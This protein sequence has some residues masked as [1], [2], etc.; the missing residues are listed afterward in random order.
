MFN[1]A[2]LA[3]EHVTK[4]LEFITNIIAWQFSLGQHSKTPRTPTCRKFALAIA[5]WGSN[6]RDPRGSKY[7]PKVEDLS[8]N[9]LLRFLDIFWVFLIGIQINNRRDKFWTNL[10]FGAF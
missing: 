9:C 7:C 10:G 4:H 5:F 8:G 2:S 3:L 1:A 6:H